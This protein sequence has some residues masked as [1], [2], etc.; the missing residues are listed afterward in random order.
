M[1]S[2]NKPTYEL[3]RRTCDTALAPLLLFKVV[4]FA[5]AAPRYVVTTIKDILRK[6]PHD[7]RFCLFILPFHHV[8]SADIPEEEIDDEYGWRYCKYLVLSIGVGGLNPAQAKISAC[9][10]Q[11]GT[12]DLQEEEE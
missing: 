9:N 11:N 1:I 2:R 10:A 8:V 6:R 4:T 12:A 7:F 5:L 3:V